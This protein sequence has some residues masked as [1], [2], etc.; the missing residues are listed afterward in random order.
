M[1]LANG[2]LQVSFRHVT[3]WTVAT[4]R[5]FD[6]ALRGKTRLGRRLSLALKKWRSHDRAAPAVRI[7]RPS[8]CSIPSAT[9]GLG[10]TQLGLARFSIEN[11]LLP[12]YHMASHLSSRFLVSCPSPFLDALTRKDR[13][14]RD[15]VA[16]TGYP[17]GASAGGKRA[18]TLLKRHSE[19]AF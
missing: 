14:S 2:Y 9:A 8:F 19:C 1:S 10:A 11:P 7:F 16:A 18:P 17:V 12:C 3:R 6:H 4:C 5:I 13:R 15:S